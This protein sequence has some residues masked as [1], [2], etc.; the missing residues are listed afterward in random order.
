MKFNA[1]EI[2]TFEKL[3]EHW[4]K[5]FSVQILNKNFYQ[6]LF[7][8]YL[9]AKRLIKIPPI[10]KDEDQDEDTLTS[11]FTIR[12][13]TRLL[14]VWFVKE[15][16]LIPSFIFQK[17]YI[18]D[19]LKKFD[20]SS[21]SDG[22]YYKAILQNLFFAT[23]N[24][25][26]E[27]EAKGDDEQRQFLVPEKRKSTRDFDEQYLDQ[28]KYR[29]DNL[30]KEPQKLLD[31]LSNVPFL[32]GGLFECLDYREGNSE[33]RYDGFSST[34]KKQ[35]LVPDILFFG[36]ENDV[37]LSKDFDDDV[38]MKRT[39]V[40]GIIDILNSYKF[41][42]TENTPLEEEIALDPELL[43][44]VFENLLASYNPET[45]TPA[46]KMTGSFYTPRE[47][48]SY[49]V[50]ES[51]RA[52]LLQR[53]LDKPTG[54]VEVGKTQ[55]DM[56]GN[57][58]RKGQ[59]K[60]EADIKSQPN[61]KE[62]SVFE[63]KLN[64][65]FLYGTDEN[66]FTPDETKLLIE[67]ISN[68]KI[69]DPACGSGA[70]PMG[71]LHRM[72]H[73]LSKLDQN[74]NEWKKAQQKKAERDLEIAK[75]M[76]DE[77]IR[78]NA[79]ES[80]EQRI[81]Y[82]SES[83]NNPFHEL[84]YTRKLFLIENCI[85][86]VDIQQIAVQIAK[87]RFFISL[88]AEQKT[89]DTRPNRN[90]LS[91]P[92]LET[93]FVAANTLIALEK[94]QAQ[95]SLMDM[96]PAIKK[97]EDELRN[98]RSK[99]FF[100]RRYSEKKKLHKQEKQCRQQLLKV[101]TDSDYKKSVA[102]QM[103]SW[104]PFDQLHHAIFFDTETMFELI[105]I[106][107]DDGV[108]DIVIG[109]PPYISYY[110]N[111][112]SQLTKNE[113]EYFLNNYTIVEKLND[114]IN[115]MN[116][117][118]EK[119]L[120]LLKS[121]GYISFITNKTIAV[122]PSYLSTRDFILNNSRVTY[123]VT[124]LDPFEAIVDCVIF[125]FEKEKTDNN[126][127]LKWL[128]GNISNFSFKNAQEITRNPKKELHFS[129]NNSILN[130]IEKFKSTLG[131]ILLVNRGVNIGG[132]FDYFLSPKKKNNFYPYLSGT[133]CIKPYRYTW[134]EQVDGYFKFDLK[135]EQEL[136]EKGETLVLGNPDRYIGE[137]LFIP[138][139]SQKLMCCFLNEQIYSA[140]GLMVGSPISESHSIK[141]SC[142]LIN[143]KLFSFYA[144]EREIL[145]K[146]NKATP[147]MGVKGLSSIPTPILSTKNEKYFIILVDKILSGKKSG[148][149]TSVLEHE[150]DVMVYKLYNL[151]HE[152]IK[153]IDPNFSM[154]KNAY[155]A[156]PAIEAEKV[157][158]TAPSENGKKKSKRRIS[159]E[160][161]KGL[162][163]E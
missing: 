84:D 92:N 159:G 9:W 49:M 26:M 48:V 32:N 73:L 45:K 127:E 76:S 143:S 152:E 158:I 42:I 154:S 91:M 142:A 57:N 114:R 86:G 126:Y 31:V 106:K 21:E 103:S 46:R 66:P 63:E 108:F 102:E 62:K 16:K 119:G 43:G 14:F 33:K 27:K 89:D 138:E 44:K 130:K 105:P 18:K 85:Y 98:L 71:I 59:L 110:S 144:I 140:Y 40:R 65:L 38:K 163:F 2:D 131:D 83:F 115:S 150:I 118:V 35:S 160:L 95:L 68:C 116:L 104:N 134:N 139:S 30:L 101:L 77:E 24:T 117:F 135:K 55:S 29:H 149:D 120:E 99:I 22:N 28:T 153:T 36:K 148:K 67:G 137:K 147:H 113:R 136:R 94:P 4:K 100:T 52:Y 23:L 5:V 12:L 112:G 39:K 82:I 7:H 64:K 6:E 11:I 122:L 151:T 133:H 161:L 111:T 157:E 54:F 129:E 97:T 74:N 20:S 37:D 56:F 132:C 1:L 15:K 79:I 10:P 70:F 155:D 87:L 81:K 123:L 47:I 128:K 88:M 75:T 3:Y 156:L 34:E 60:M 141:Y 121:N 41:T 25:P 96:N 19:L 51:L 50:D 8:W 107:T 125:G 61:E 17:D 72:V 124:N 69:L 58:S 90:I 53:L 80:A 109:N 146:G 93:K 13:L 145:R 162:D 78:A